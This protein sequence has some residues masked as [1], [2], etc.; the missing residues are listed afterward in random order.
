MSF[1]RDC[2]LTATYLIN[3]FSTSLLKNKSPFELLYGKP[4][5][6]TNLKSFGC[7]CY[8]TIPKVHRDKFAPRYMPCVFLGHPFAKKGY[9]LY[10]L[11]S[12]SSLVTTDV[13]FHEHNFPF[14]TS[15]F[16]FSTSYTFTSSSVSDDYFS[17]LTYSI[18]QIST[19]APPSPISPSS[20]SPVHSPSSSHVSSSAPP[21]VVPL[22]KSTRSHNPP[23]YFFDYVY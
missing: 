18:S 23:G 21:V 12:K 20:P 7:L 19:F 14:S 1:W 17:D 4:P 3:R 22:R 11:H 5:S 16:T 15:S 8:A 6:Y 13:L 9:K 2:I 10:N